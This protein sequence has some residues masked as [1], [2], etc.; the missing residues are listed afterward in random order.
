V[1]VD[2]DPSNLAQLP[3]GLRA[4]LRGSVHAAS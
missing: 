4:L 2:D 3:D 1:I